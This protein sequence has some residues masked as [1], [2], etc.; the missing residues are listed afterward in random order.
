MA[1]SLV[2]TKFVEYLSKQSRDG[3]EDGDGFTSE[4]QREALLLL[5]FAPYLLVLT[6]VCSKKNMGIL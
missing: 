2:M 1:T 6:S 4:V 3:K 5:Q